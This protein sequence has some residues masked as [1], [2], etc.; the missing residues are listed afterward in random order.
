VA[1]ESGGL[2][3]KLTDQF[4][5]PAMPPAVTD[6]LHC[7]PSAISFDSGRSWGSQR[8]STRHWRP[9][10]RLRAGGPAGAPLYRPKPPG[11]PTAGLRGSHSDGGGRVTLERTPV[12]GQM[13]CHASAKDSVEPT[14]RKTALRV[15]HAT[16]PSPAPPMRKATAWRARAHRGGGPPQYPARSTIGAHI[17]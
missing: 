1:S 14:G 2:T 16:G 13:L 5:T 11:S 17:A 15:A 4:P 12:G 3:C 10:R 6:G 9:D 8:H 7:K